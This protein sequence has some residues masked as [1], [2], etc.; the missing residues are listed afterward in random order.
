[1]IARRPAL[2]CIWLILPE[3]NRS[4]QVNIVVRMTKAKSVDQRSL[5]LFN[6]LKVKIGNQV[7]M[8]SSFETLFSH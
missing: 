8:Q 3:M 5:G 4:S 2:D 1:M 7:S 6:Q